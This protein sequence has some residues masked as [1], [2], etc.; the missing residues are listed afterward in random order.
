MKRIILFGAGMVGLEALEKL[1]RENVAYFC[2]NGK[3]GKKVGDISIISIEELKKIHKEYDVV[4]TPQGFDVR[5]D[6]GIQLEANYIPYSF[7]ETSDN[8]LP[9][10]I[11]HVYGSAPDNLTYEYN[12]D[13]MKGLESRVD[14]SMDMI[15]V[16]FEKYRD[17]FSG[18]NIDLYLYMHDFVYEANVIAKQLGIPYIFAYSTLYIISD[19]VIPFPDYRA[20]YDS[21]KGRFEDTPLKCREASHS[22]WEDNRVY[23][24][25]NVI[26]DQSRKWLM[27]LGEKYPDYFKIEDMKNANGDEYIP[28]YKSA[29]YKYLID[30]RGTGWTDRVKILMS[31]GRPVFLVDRPYKEWYFDKLKP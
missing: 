12:C 9:M 24:R 2:D 15:K 19:M 3:S 13:G 6:I 22:K 31:L 4:V 17:R 27:D 10:R 21:E 18:K 28:M 29:K 23:W 5:H 1:G 7:Y 14:I 8:K 25:G 16:M 30:V 26:T 11:M 20:F